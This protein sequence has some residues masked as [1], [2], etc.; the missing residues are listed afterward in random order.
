MSSTT[1][2]GACLCGRLAFE[3]T[4]PTKWVGHCHC[5]MCRR[6][7]GA[8]FVTW[9]G[10]ADWNFR[11]KHG[12]E[13]LTWYKSSPGTQRGFC[14]QCGSSLFFRSSR[15]PG[16]THITLG[17]FTSAIDREPQ[18]HVFWDAHV[19]W[20]ELADTLPR[21]TEAEMAPKP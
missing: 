3:I 19:P 14:N 21:R 15:W 10:V 7:H 16:E 8:A 1:A 6:A 13:L 5:S 12:A 20:V 18:G 4:L 2:S 11:L 9:V 17:N